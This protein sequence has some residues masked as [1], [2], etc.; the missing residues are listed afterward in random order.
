VATTGDQ[1]AS[2]P[3]S[4]PDRDAPRFKYTEYDD[5]PGS[6]HNR[7]V[8]LVPE[9]SSV[10][11]FGCATGYM[12]DVLTRRK[13]CR[14]TGIELD[15]EAAAEASSYCERVIVGDAETLDL[16][17]HLG[18]ERFEA[19]LFADVLEHLREP[20]R[21]LRRVR[22]FVAQEGV[23]IASI[24]NVAHAS[25]RR[26]LLAGRFRYRARGLLDETHLRF[27]TRDSIRDLFEENGYIVTHWFRV[28]APAG[29]SELA[30]DARGAPAVDDFLAR[31]PE[32]TTYQFVVRAVP[33]DAGA[34]LAAVRSLLEEAEAELEELRGLPEELGQ[35]ASEVEA[36][37]AELEAVRAELEAELQALRR[38]HEAQ[39]RHLVSERLA[40]ADQFEGE[41]EPLRD[42][43]EWRKG[44][45]EAQEK[46]LAMVKQSRSL[47][48]TEPLRRIAAIVRRR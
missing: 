25:V 3:T 15:P 1:R 32:A 8:D 31:D 47:R 17:E 48:Y 24:P 26:S 20:G 18:D 39:A 5:S 6:T 34:Q 14:V 33:S 16:E 45:M 23:V 28:V 4:A 38:A 30:E 42:E 12:S 11:E 44:V 35:R 37:R 36:V 2:E 13:G 22:P 10:L 46:E 21:L 7:V 40:F 43:I 41:I 19:V 27:F 29:E 9:S